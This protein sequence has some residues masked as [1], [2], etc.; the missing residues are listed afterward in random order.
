MSHGLN[1]KMF[2]YNMLLSLFLKKG[3]EPELEPGGVE[4]HPVAEGGRVRPRLGG[5]HVLQVRVLWVLPYRMYLF[6]FFCFQ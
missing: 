6:V 3:S 4:D 2:L 1:V 5:R